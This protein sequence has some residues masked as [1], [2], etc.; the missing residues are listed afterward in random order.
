MDSM[1]PSPSALTSWARKRTLQLAAPQANSRAPCPAATPS[2]V[3]IRSTPNAVTSTPT[4]ENLIITPSFRTSRNTMILHF[5]RF[6]ERP[7]IGLYNSNGRRIPGR[8]R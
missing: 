8:V 6:R 7:D 4:S 2:A 3:T 5:F 1:G